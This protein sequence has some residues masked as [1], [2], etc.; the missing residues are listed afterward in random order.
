M[1]EVSGF[2]VVEALRE[3]P[4]TACIPILVVTA[5]W[6]TDEDRARLNGYVSTIMSKTE[7][8]LEH[9]SSEIRRAM[10]GRSVEV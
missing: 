1:P 3:Q 10:A 4:A 2:G 8:G 5:K 6:I 7:F 9:L